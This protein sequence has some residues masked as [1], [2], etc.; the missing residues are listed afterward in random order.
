M[1]ELG[2]TK[3][4]EMEKDK[5]GNYYLTEKYLVALCE[6]NKQY[7]IPEHND[8]LFLHYKGLK[9]IE[10]L[11]NYVNLIGLWLENNSIKQISGISHLEKLTTLYLQQNL[12]ERIDGLS[13]LTNL[14][15]LDLSFN[16]IT[17]VENL[18]EL[19]SLEN[20]NLSNNLIVDYKN[21][22][23]L[24]ECKSLTSLNLSENLIEYGEGILE[25]FFQLQN[26]KN[27]NFKENPA[28]SNISMYRK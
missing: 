26:L 15:T 8:R 4:A 6:E 10:A 24:E 9:K 25:F 28:R 20:L 16:N 21:C 5:D 1:N 2:H 23:G 18:E 12:I 19:S 27:F 17:V 14:V 22:K 7:A 11:D 13:T 3:K